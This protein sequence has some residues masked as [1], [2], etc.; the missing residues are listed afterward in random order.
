MIGV[1]CGPLQK[2]EGVIKFPPGDNYMDG[3][4]VGPASFS[5]KNRFFEFFLKKVTFT[6]KPEYFL[7]GAQQRRC[8]NG[9]W[10]ADWWAWCRGL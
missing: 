6:C 2:N 1:S 5:K 8:T 4:T 7:H 10:N 9:T 3:V